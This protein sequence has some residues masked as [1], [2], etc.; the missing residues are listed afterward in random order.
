VSYGLPI[1]YGSVPG[2]VFFCFRG[3]LG[4]IELCYNAIPF[5]LYRYIPSIG[6]RAILYFC[7][8]LVYLTTPSVT[9][10]TWELGW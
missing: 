3:L 1:T 4:I 6:V 5:A 10:S 2:N 8:F 7:L 9:C